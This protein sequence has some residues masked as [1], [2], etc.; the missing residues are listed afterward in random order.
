MHVLRSLQAKETAVIRKKKRGTTGG[1]ELSLVMPSG[2]AQ[3]QLGISSAV[4]QVTSEN[5]DTALTVVLVVV[6]AV[7]MTALEFL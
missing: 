2:Q 6:I 7:G 1:R 5:H 3:P 4:A